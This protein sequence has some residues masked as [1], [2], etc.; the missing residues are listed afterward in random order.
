VRVGPPVKGDFLLL[1]VNNQRL[2]EPADAIAAHVV[3]AIKDEKAYR[4]AALVVNENDEVELKQGGPR[5]DAAQTF[6]PFSKEHED[7]S[8]Q[9]QRI[10]DTINEKRDNAATDRL[11]TIIVWPERELSS[12]ANLE[13][14][15]ALGQ[16]GGGPIAILCP[17]ADPEKARR[18]AA[19]L[20]PPEG[21]KERITVRSP[22]TP[23]LIEHIRDVIHAGKPKTQPFAAGVKR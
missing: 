16:D 1:L 4:D 7:L 14:L 8:G 20:R 12:A 3:E 17:D 19:A 21:G 11:P 10:V 6:R 15:A 9:V 2:H 23:E 22:K 5:P 18:L 13:A